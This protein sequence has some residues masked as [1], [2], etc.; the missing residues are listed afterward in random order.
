MTEL[1]DNEPHFHGLLKK[2]VT[3]NATH[4]CLKLYVFSEITRDDAVLDDG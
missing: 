2:I 3:I 1:N 4:F